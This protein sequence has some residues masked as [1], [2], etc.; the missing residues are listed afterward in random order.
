[1]NI[2]EKIYSLFAIIFAGCL[3]ASL[4]YFPQ[5]R[6][7][8]LLIPISILG[9]I[10]NIGLIFLVLRDIFSRQFKNQGAKYIWVALVLFLWPSIL[11]YLPIYGFKSRTS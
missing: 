3:I 11:F 10:I 9:L 4:I 2:F 6:Q 8:N 7:F 5:L 1:M